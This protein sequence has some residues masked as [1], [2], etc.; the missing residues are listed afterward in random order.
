MKDYLLDVLD[1][2][3]YILFVSPVMYYKEMVHPLYVAHKRMNHIFKV[4]PLIVYLLFLAVT[5]VVFP[6]AQIVVMV[7]TPL[8]VLLVYV[9]DGKVLKWVRGLIFKEEK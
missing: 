3:K 7:F 4:F 2:W 5:V 6:A 9:W 8:I 1:G